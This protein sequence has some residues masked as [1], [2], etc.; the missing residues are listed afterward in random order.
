MLNKA[1]EYRV[2]SSVSNDA[3]NELFVAAWSEH[4][5]SDFTQTLLHSLAYICAYHDDNLIG[6]V[7]VAWDGGIHAFLLDTTVHP[8]MQRR[9]I[10]QQ[11]V[12]EAAQVA[13]ARGIVWL[14]V[15]YE[16]HLDGFYKGCGFEETLAGLMRLNS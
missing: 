7:N 4:T 6:F 1:I 10:G 16:A 11:L 5:L 8:S 15:D 12:R 3:L 2:S 13:K 14:H 9:G